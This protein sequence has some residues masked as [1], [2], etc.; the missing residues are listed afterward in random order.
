MIPGG[1]FEEPCCLP[2]IDMSIARIK[3]RQETYNEPLD[4][5]GLNERHVGFGQTVEQTMRLS[6][7]ALQ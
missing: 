2:G 3:T 1:V 7:Q 4:G 6:L 5:Q